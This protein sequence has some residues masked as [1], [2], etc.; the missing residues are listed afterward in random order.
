[1]VPIHIDEQTALAI[2][3]DAQVRGLSVA[4][5]LRLLVS[6]VPGSIRPDWNDIEREIESL[7]TAGGSLP[8][9]FARN[10]IYSEHD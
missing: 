8:E 9:D 5:Y 6:S 1:M 3:H 2:E 10:D 7:S 4:D